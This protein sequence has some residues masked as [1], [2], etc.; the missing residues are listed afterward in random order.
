MAERGDHL[1]VV[2]HELRSGLLDVL[3]GAS[4]NTLARAHLLVD[5]QFL[6]DRHD[7]A[8]AWRRRAGCRVLD[9]ARLAAGVAVLDRAARGGDVLPGV[10]EAQQPEHAIHRAIEL[11]VE[12]AREQRVRC[13][14]RRLRR[15]CSA[16][17]GSCSSA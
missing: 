2:V 8:C 5:R 6:E 11:V 4:R 16:A 10:D 1:I 9:G 3:P 12:R 14:S 7:D 15:G 17:S 13:A